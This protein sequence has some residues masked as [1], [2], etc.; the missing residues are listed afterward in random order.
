MSWHPDNY[1]YRKPILITGSAGAGADYKM[2]PLMVY[3]E[4]TTTN[5]EQTE[6]DAYTSLMSGALYIRAGQKKTIYGTITKLSFYLSKTGSPTGDITFAIRRTS[7]D[8]VIYSD[9]WGDAGD[10]STD[11]TR[12]WKE[13]EFSSPT[14]ISEE[15]YLSCEYGSGDLS[16]YVNVRLK[17]T[18]VVADECFSRYAGGAWADQ[19]TWDCA[20]KYTYTPGVTPGVVE[21]NNLCASFPDDIRFTDDDG[22]TELSYD[23]LGSDADLAKFL[24][25]VKDDLGSNQSV[26]IYFG[27]SGASD[28]SSEFRENFMGY[29]E[30]DV[31]AD[32]ITVASYEVDHD[33]YD[34]EE[35]RVHVDKTSVQNFEHYITVQG[36]YYD[37]GAHGYPWLLADTVDDVKGLHD[38]SKTYLEL[39]LYG[40]N[41]AN[42]QIHILE[43]YSGSRYKDADYSG[44][45]DTPY[46][47]GIKKVGTAFTL[48]IYS[49][50]IFETEV[51]SQSITLHADHDLQYA[52]AANTWNNGTTKHIEVDADNFFF[53]QIIVSEP[54]WGT[55]GTLETLTEITPTTLNMTTAKYSPIL[56]TKVVPT[57]L[58]LTLTGYSSILKEVLTPEVLAL[59][60]TKY[61]PILKEVLTPSTLA[62]TTTGYSPILKEILTPSTLALTTT[63][64]SPVLKEVITPS[65]LALITTGFIPVIDTEVIVPTMIALTLTK[66]APTILEDVIDTDTGAGSE[67]VSLLVDA[68]LR[69]IAGVLE[70]LSIDETFEAVSETG[71]GTDTVTVDKAQVYRMVSQVRPLYNILSIIRERYKLNPTVRE[72]YK[73]KSHVREG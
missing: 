37:T 59:I 11:P 30:T 45:Y 1:L 35:T 39:M 15:V 9:V 46:Y 57:I 72:R 21:L 69:E 56:D 55:P 40:Y 42:M 28:G 34:N 49:D 53:R 61:E 29:T 58:S 7:D 38:A 3:R 63:K 62:L 66:Y 8:G 25:Q 27:K 16:N 26:Y 70:G 41:A 47:L 13:V 5:V 67:E 71:Q 44:S 22:V 68:L 52:Y 17:A 18:D 12:E 2:S 32:H 6:E 23:V 54:V 43:G 65:T 36:K 24:V 20:Y 51:N 19:A 48:K 33:A 60:I 64:Y 4:G 50:A 31:G 73:V 10:L 14:T